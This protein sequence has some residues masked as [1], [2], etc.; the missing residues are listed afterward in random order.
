M[1]EEEAVAEEQEEKTTEETEE[2]SEE[3]GVDHWKQFSRKNE[4]AAKQAQKELDEA[5]K[6]IKQFEDKDKSEQDKLTEKATEAEKRAANAE[7]E[8]L[9]LRVAS[10]K[11]LPTELA[12]RLRGETEEELEADADRLSELV[13]TDGTPSVD[14]DAGKGKSSGG[15]SFNDIIRGA[16]A[17]Q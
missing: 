3:Q 12:E 9:R 16:S 1:A 14:T 7:T 5:R 6:Q 4:K 17:R 11:K 15:K 2:K 8:L 10:K 13:K